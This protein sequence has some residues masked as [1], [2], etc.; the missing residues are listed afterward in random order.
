MAIDRAYDLI[1]QRYTAERLFYAAGNKLTDEQENAVNSY[2]TDLITSLGARRISR[3][4]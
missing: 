3:R 2:I 4:N 1:L